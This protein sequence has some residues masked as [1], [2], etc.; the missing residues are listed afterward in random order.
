MRPCKGKRAWPPEFG[1][2]L[3]KGEGLS[4]EQQVYKGTDCAP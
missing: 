4:S 1:G 2:T 3:P